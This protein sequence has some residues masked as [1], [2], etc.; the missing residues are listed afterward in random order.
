MEA[1]KAL[2]YKNAELN[3]IKKELG[4]LE[5]MTSDQ[6]IRKGLGILAKRKGV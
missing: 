6:Y 2:G 5:A 1:L 3:S 4:T